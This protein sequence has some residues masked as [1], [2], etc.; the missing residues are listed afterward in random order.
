MALT[1]IAEMTRSM[2][3]RR[4]AIACQWRYCHGRT[5]ESTDLYCPTHAQIVD[6]R[7]ATIAL[8]KPYTVVCWL[9]AARREESWNAATKELWVKSGWLR[10]DQCGSGVVGVEAFDMR[11]SDTPTVVRDVELPRIRLVR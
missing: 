8:F 11:D 2:R 1:L 10:C 5:I 7:L 6:D 4:N 9:C 3:K